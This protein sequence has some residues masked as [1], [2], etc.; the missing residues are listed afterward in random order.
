MSGAG[1]GERANGTEG[2]IYNIEGKDWKN[3]IRRVDD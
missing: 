2:R 3:E 1:T